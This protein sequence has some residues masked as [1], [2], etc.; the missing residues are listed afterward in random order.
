MKRE[1]KSLYIGVALFLAGI[2]VSGVVSN[3][4]MRNTAENSRKIEEESVEEIA[5]KI[6]E[7]ES[8]NDEKKENMLPTVSST[9]VLDEE[10]KEQPFLFEPPLKGKILTPYS[11]EKLVFSETLKDY[12]N[13]GGVDIEANLLEKVMSCERGIVKETK[14]DRFL[15]IT[16]VIDHENGFETVYSNLST[17]NM[18]K[19]GDRVEKGMI[20]SGVGDTAISE[21]GEQTH[22]HF[23][24][25]KDGKAVNPEEYISFK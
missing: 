19:V 4:V 8:Y 7:V 5:E 24:L 21:S 11:G 25:Y 17:E 3:F 16:I 20:I 15:G 23:E 2:I 6:Y 12:R 9:E 18:V 14:Y 22:L 13:H 10:Q 1:R